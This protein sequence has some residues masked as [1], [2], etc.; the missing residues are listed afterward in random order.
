MC[1]P[2]RGCGGCRI[3]NGYRQG[4]PDGV[5]EDTGPIEALVDREKG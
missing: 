4:T 5:R 2:S 1:N 3:A